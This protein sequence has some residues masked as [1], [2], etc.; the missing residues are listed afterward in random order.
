LE[1]WETGSMSAPLEDWETG[2]TPV[3]KAVWL[4][5]DELAFQRRITPEVQEHTGGV[6]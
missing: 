3:P 1:R 4:A 5:L 2:E 6:H